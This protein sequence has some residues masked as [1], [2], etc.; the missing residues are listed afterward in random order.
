MSALS[1]L[2][3]LFSAIACLPGI[4]TPPAGGRTLVADATSRTLTFTER[5]TYQYAIEEVYWRHRNWPKEN[6]GS[7]PPLDVVVSGREIAEKVGDYLCKSQL[8][9]DQR[10]SPITAGELQ[11]EMDRMATQT[12]DP[13]MLR[14]VF[15]MLGSDPFVIA[16]CLAKP[17]LA[18]RLASELS[19]CTNSRDG[20]PSRPLSSAD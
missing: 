6:P 19:V 4:G 8:V 12:K 16:E 17:I 9:A 20:S 14:E 1:R 15:E 7:K 18:E 11:A 10:G 13:N 3:L 5:V 2:A